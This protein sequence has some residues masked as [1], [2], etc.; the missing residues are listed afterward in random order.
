MY[1]Y[2][3]ICIW[4]DQGSLISKN[5]LCKRDRHSLPWAHTWSAWTCTLY[6]PLG[7]LVAPISINVVVLFDGHARY[8][9]YWGWAGAPPSFLS[10]PRTLQITR[11]CQQGILHELKQILPGILAGSLR[12]P[13]GILARMSLN[14]QTRVYKNLQECLVT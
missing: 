6:G 2:I 1:I 10:G 11:I 9:G 4:H 14:L 13:R 3:Y 12:H 5:K 7:C 8:T